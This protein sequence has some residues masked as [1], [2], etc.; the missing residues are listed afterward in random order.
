[1]KGAVLLVLAVLLAVAN[2]ASLYTVC[3]NCYYYVKNRITV[4]SPTDTNSLIFMADGRLYRSVDDGKT[5]NSAYNS[6]TRMI[7]APSNPSLI[8]LTGFMDNLT[9]TTDGGSTFTS[10]KTPLSNGH[11][12][13]EYLVP[14]PTR[15]G[16]LMLNAF[17]GS[18]SLEMRN[19]TIYI[20]KDYAKTWN[21]YFQNQTYACSGRWGNTTDTADLIFFQYKDMSFGYSSDYKTYNKLF[22]RVDLDD[23]V[24]T[25]HYQFISVEDPNVFE[26]YLYVSSGRIDPLHTNKSS[27]RLAEFPFGEDIGVNE[28]YYLDDSTDS[29]FIGVHQARNQGWTTIYSSGTYG[30]SYRLSVD[31]IY[32]TWENIDFG[33]FRGMQGIY[34]ANTIRDR[35]SYYYVGSTKITWDNGGSWN[36]LKV[37]ANDMNGDDWSCSVD[38]RLNLVGPN[39]GN[40]PQGWHT[41]SEAIGMIIAN[42]NVARYLSDNTVSPSTFFSRDS[43]VTWNQV[44]P[45]ATYFAFGNRGSIIVAAPYGGGA[46][47][48]YVYYS[49]DEAQTW[50]QFQLV[51]SGTGGIYFTAVT[52]HPSGSGYVFI[53]SGR[54]NNVNTVWT[55]NFEDVQ[56]TNC[57]LTDYEQYTPHDGTAANSCFMGA[58]TTY[59]RRKQSSVCYIPTDTEYVMSQSPCRCSWEDYECAFNY[60]SSPR[61]ETGGFTCTK[62]APDRPCIPGQQYYNSTGLGYTLIPDT[63]CTPANGLNLVGNLFTCGGVATSTTGSPNTNNGGG[64]GSTA[65]AVIIPLLLIGII[66]GAVVAYKKNE[67][68]HNWVNSFRGQSTT[69]Y[70]K[71]SNEDSEGLLDS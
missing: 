13:P 2:A 49:L 8:Y 27:Y 55:L 41:S 12:Y 31:E 45:V 17:Q 18:G 52:A 69:N 65:A 33:R 15:D 62:N 19:C 30:A 5:W 25:K 51:A 35:N 38:C 3:T 71:L 46:S 39:S 28:F 9:I 40:G 22:D 50:Q 67:G 29:E 34:L 44:L 42:G 66:V 56:P 37:P 16:W 11:F 60:D 68:F 53:V 47:I 24:L 48:N 63:L 23:T 14:H 20:S 64:G 59:Q 4:L 32:G 58:L 26:L 21:A 57:A 54:I 36:Y 70:G 1:M 10:A 7:P 43:G 61:N 6:T